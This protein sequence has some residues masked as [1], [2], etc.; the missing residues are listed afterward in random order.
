MILSR[1]LVLWA[2]GLA[3][4]AILAALYVFTP[5][6]SSERVQQAAVAGAI[7]V[8]G[9]IF[10]FAT[11]EVGVLLDYRRK[12]E[13][14]QFVLRAEIYDYQNV[15]DDGSIDEALAV[16]KRRYNANKKEGAEMYFSRISAPVVF[17]AMAKEIYFLPEG[18]IDVVVQFYSSLSQV[19]LFSAEFREDQFK[20]L[21]EKSKYAAFE[22]YLRLRQE[23]RELAELAVRSLNKSLG[24]E[25]RNVR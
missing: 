1:K 10:T 12:S 8:V 25:V 2:C 19:S 18:V 7:V 4:S 21:P 22:D 13:D 15:L 9:W 23:A 5:D 20:Q 14:M 16:L 3:I 24:I 6:F 17:D 11:R